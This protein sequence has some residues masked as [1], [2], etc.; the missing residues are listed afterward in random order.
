MVELSAHASN[1]RPALKNEV[2]RVPTPDV[3]LEALEVSR[4]GAVRRGEAAPQR[5]PGLVAAQA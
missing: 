5:A 3:V 4:D 1:Q 2:Y